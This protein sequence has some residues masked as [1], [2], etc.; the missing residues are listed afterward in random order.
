MK[1]VAFIIFFS[2]FFGMFLLGSWYVFNRGMQALPQS[3][4]RTIFPW[5][6]WGLAAAFVV[7]QFLERGNPTLFS[8]MITYVGSFWLV[9]LLYL[10]MFILAIDIIRLANHF[11]GF[12]PEAWT[13][14]VLSGKNLF[15]AVTSITLII[16]AAGHINAIIPRIVNVDISIDKKAGKQKEI[17]VAFV[18]DIHMGFIIGNHRVKRMVD[19]INSE[20]PDLVLFGGDLV[21]HNPLPVIKYNMGENF[22]RLHPPLGVYAVTGNHEYI[23]KPDI[24]I[25]YLSKF[26]IQYLRDTLININD[27]LLLGGREDKDKMRFT[28]TPR[29]P[30]S[31]LVNGVDRSLPILLMDHQPVEYDSVMQTG[32]DLMVSGHTHRGQFWPFRYI[33]RKVY[34]LDWGL[35]KKGNTH[36][37]V[38]SGL[39]TWGPP[40]RIGTRSEIVILHLKLN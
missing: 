32:V 3:A 38:S 7:G 34:E 33:T 25:E 8:Q 40:V 24:S 17:K 30:V 39:G 19:K 5:M 35:L 21:D 23:G 9:T 37:F 31:Q 12:I 4:L 1:H 6:F 16:V 15:F 27:V 13:Q 22:S 26:G 18:S 14:T 10:F 11:I 20:N 28:G 2:V 29:K 36:F